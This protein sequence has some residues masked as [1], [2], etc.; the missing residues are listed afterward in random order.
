MLVGY[1][2]DVVLI[3]FSSS[4]LDNIEVL[5]KKYRHI[6]YLIQSINIF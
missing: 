4:K 3:I 6:Q 5:K 2:L 1:T